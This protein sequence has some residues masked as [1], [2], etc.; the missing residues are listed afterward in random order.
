MYTVRNENLRNIKGDFTLKKGDETH[1]CSI[2]GE[3]LEK[4]RP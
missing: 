3:D 2:T 4:L 1:T